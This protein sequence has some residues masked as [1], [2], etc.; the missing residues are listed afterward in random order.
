MANFIVTARFSEECPVEAETR[1]DAEHQAWRY[2]AERPDKKLDGLMVRAE[3][4]TSEAAYLRLLAK[5]HCT[6]DYQAGAALQWMSAEARVDF[7]M[8][9]FYFLCV[10]G[11]TR[12]GVTRLVNENFGHL[13]K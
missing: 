9:Q 5:A 4:D 2:Y 13:S 8:R 11:Y 7:I 12:E 1:E 3:E 10:T 6:I